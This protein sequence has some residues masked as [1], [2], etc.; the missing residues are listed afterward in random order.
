M[1]LEWQC[2]SSPHSHND[3]LSQE[4]RG[5]R[6]LRWNKPKQEILKMILDFWEKSIFDLTL[7]CESTFSAVNLVKPKPTGRRPQRVGHN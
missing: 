2:N 6:A 5:K 4:I 3:L 7:V 1:S